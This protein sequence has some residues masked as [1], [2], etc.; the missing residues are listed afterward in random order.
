MNLPL[1]NRT[2]VQNLFLKKNV[3]FICK[4]TKIRIINIKLGG[5]VSFGN[6]WEV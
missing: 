4:T 1:K 6:Y 5:F 2:N 3:R